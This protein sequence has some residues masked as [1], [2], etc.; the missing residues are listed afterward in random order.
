MSAAPTSGARRWLRLALGIALSAAALWLA[1]RKASLAEISHALG[2]MDW[3][4]IP[5]MF[6]LKFGIIVVKAVRWRVELQAMA[7]GPY[8]HTFRAVGLGYFG[9]LVLPFKLGELLR[10]GLL[11]R[12][13]PDVPPGAALA[14]IAAERAIDG[15][16]LA[17]MVGLAL[18]STT[19]PAWVLSGTVVLMA[20]MLGVIVLAML[21][22]VH[23][24]ILGM[25]P[26]S[27]V[28]G[29]VRRAIVAITRGT[30][31][32][33]KPGALLR[34]ASLTAL[35]WLGEALVFFCATRALGLP[36]SFADVL[37][38]TLLMS[39]GMLIPSAPGQIGTHQALTVFFLKP[40]GVTS[41]AAVSTSVVLQAVVLSTLGSIGAYVLVRQ[42]GARELVRNPT[43]DS[44]LPA[45]SAPPAVTRPP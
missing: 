12:H 29:W 37:I 16:V 17:G 5:A 42:A 44:T 36:L 38:V 21:T 28:L 33:R 10:V 27:G 9:N 35:A 24:L 40:F 22:P 43:A 15:A 26:Q 18:T 39:V 20:V 1:L 34:S 23:A 32:L 30:S 3:R 14:T 45:D 4:W 25:L 2:A 11:K 31:V 6:G 8:R 41:S 7:P 13:N 19:A